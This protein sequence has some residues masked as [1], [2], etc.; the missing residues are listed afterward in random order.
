MTHLF[1]MSDL[2]ISPYLLALVFIMVSSI[3]ALVGLGGGCFYTALM[4]VFGVYFELI[5]TISLTLN[6]LVS[7][8]AFINYSR[9]NLVRIRLVF[10]YCVASIPM[11]YIG[12][13]LT[14]SKV[15]FQLV[16]ISTLLFVVARIYWFDR[17]AFDL[18]PGK[19]QKICIALVSGSVLGLVAGI[20]GIGGGILLVPL[21]IILRVGS[22]K[23]AAACGIVFVLVNSLSGLI[24][25]LQYYPVNFSV[26]APFCV[27]VIIGAWIG[28]L[29]GSS[30]INPVALRKTLG[31]VIL[32]AIILIVRNIWMSL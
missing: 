21:I 14:V 29:I 6:L 16:L 7:S 2:L 23:E 22:E 11:A 13:T 32:V 10:P 17:L 1:F 9:R 24:A 27:A 25:R 5:P 18:K 31:T 12:G 20:V 15:F 26:V 3:S 8:I 19:T 4:T 28:S 30:K